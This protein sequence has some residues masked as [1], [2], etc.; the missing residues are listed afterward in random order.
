MSKPTDYNKIFWGLSDHGR[1]RELQELYQINKSVITVNW[2]HP[3][4]NGTTALMR[5]AQFGHIKVVVWLL[6]TLGAKVNDANLSGNTALI[7]AAYYGHE[8]VV[9]LLLQHGAE[10]NHQNKD[11]ET[12]LSF[13]AR[14]YY[15]KVAYVLLS[16]GAKPDL[17]NYDD[18]VPM[19][20]VKGH[21]RYYSFA[22]LLVLYSD[23]N[24]WKERAAVWYALPSDDQYA[25]KAFWDNAMAKKDDKEGT[26]SMDESKTWLK[27]SGLEDDVIDQIWDLAAK[28]STALDIYGFVVALRYIALSQNGE[29]LN[30]TEMLNPEKKLIPTI[31]YPEPEEEIPP[32]QTKP[33]EEWVVYDIYDLF[34]S[35]GAEER[36]LTC[37]LESKLDG[38]GLK[39]TEEKI[40]YERL[41]IPYGF[42]KKYSRWLK[43]YKAKA[44]SGTKTTGGRTSISL[45]KPGDVQRLD[46]YPIDKWT[47]DDTCALFQ[48]LGAEP[49]D[50][51]AVRSERVT[52]AALLEY[53]DEELRDELHV[54]GG[55]RKSYKQWLEH[56]QSPASLDEYVTSRIT[57]ESE[58]KGI[59][60][61]LN[62][63]GIQSL[64]DL[65]QGRFKKELA[66]QLKDYEARY[67]GF[68]PDLPEL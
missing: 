3:E 8:D 67:P 53:K 61:T 23:P 45:L 17:K 47:I 44:G 42:V 60:S 20:T 52:G 22:S 24:S 7:L 37:L 62:S 15:D 64:E 56:R 14:R 34:V 13:A 12:A 32:F 10:V 30:E 2:R 41:A 16:H 28:G 54:P 5:A 11:G 46:V 55:T 26:L 27:M 25:Y 59:I 43:E 6:E 21:A 63:L 9:K 19:D 40:L 49:E 48:H 51:G 65:L 1:L 68:L 18:K 38:L 4:Q 50:L 58:V 36:E 57:D 29:E 39:D 31:T 35:L 66:A 33:M